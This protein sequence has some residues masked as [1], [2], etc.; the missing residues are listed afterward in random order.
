MLKNP[1]Q[2]YKREAFEMF[3]SLLH[4]INIEVI[5]IISNVSVKPPEE[6]QTL[7]EA[8]KEQHMHY[9][10]AKSVPAETP[11]N[12]PAKRAAPKVGRNEPCPCGSGKK[13]KRCHGA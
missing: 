3:K 1:V 12:A 11:D 10:S 6:T 4:D 9:S 13:Y 7:Y 8:P 5:R 2:E